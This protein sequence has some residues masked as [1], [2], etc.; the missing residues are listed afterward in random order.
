MNG[1]TNSIDTDSGIGTI[2]SHFSS[3]YIEHIVDDSLK[4]KY[5]PFIN[6]PMPN[7]VDI[8][9]RQ[10]NAV[11]VNAPDYI[12]KVKDV[13]NESFKEIILKI[14]NYYNLTFT[15]DLDNI[16]GDELYSIAHVLYDI[17]ISRFTEYMNNFFTS[18]ILNNADSIYAYLEAD[19]TS[20]KLKDNAVYARYID[21]K[22]ALIHANV[23][24]VMYNLAGY[25][26]SLDELL[27]YFLGPAQYMPISQLLLDNGDIYKNHYACYILNQM[28]SA[29]ILTNVKLY[30][31]ARTQEGIK[32]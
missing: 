4:M 6:E 24:K 22:F 30:L 32:I 2:L 3:S 28:S 18:Y 21:P 17:F 13:K 23:N 25:D 10:I 8:I 26:I 14:C 20:I 11:L 31:Q 16:F 19:E 29:G 12:D 1:Y 9:N 5:R 27:L 15:G 7:I